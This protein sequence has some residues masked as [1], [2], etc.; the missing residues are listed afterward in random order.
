MDQCMH[1][2]TPDLER[3]GKQQTGLPVIHKK[4]ASHAINMLYM[5]SQGIMLRIAAPFSA[6]FTSKQ[7]LCMQAYNMIH[8]LKINM[9]NSA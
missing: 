6:S 7:L 8:A 5:V 1:M 3:A 9:P 4:I 2:H